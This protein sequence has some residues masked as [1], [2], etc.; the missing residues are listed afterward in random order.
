M[1]EGVE[2][3]SATRRSGG[4]VDRRA[5]LVGG[6]AAAGLA[7]A[8]RALA[9]GSPYPNRPIRVIVPFAAGGPSDIIARIVADALY[10]QLGQ[11]LVIDNRAGGGANIGIGVAA[12]AEPDGY[13]LLITT[14]AFVINPSLYK[15]IPFDP[16]K[17]FSPI[18]DLAISPQMLSVMP[19]YVNTLAEFIAKAK[20]APGALNYSSPGVGTQAQLTVE[21]LKLRA[22]ID[23]VHV[24]FS[25]GPPAVQAL[26]SGSVQLTTNAVPT[27]EK[28]AQAGTIHP[29]AVSGKAR[30]FALPD[31]PTLVESGFADFTVDAWTGVAAP[32]GTPPEI[33]QMLNR[34]INES[35]GSAE[36]KAGLARFSAIAQTGSPQDF[37]EL[38]ASELPK[39]AAIVKLAGARI[40][41]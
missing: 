25:G 24:P 29:L 10:P 33:V 22:G 32:A 8:P 12:R 4:G 20:A 2:S 28:L 30:Y 5:L 40:E 38:I 11:T 27:S 23:I 15:K 36:A 1:R 17:D 19:G 31:V 9:Q 18:S 13:T 26:L 34:S 3:M 39:W 21:L 16:I 7:A 35:L 41:Q 14:S 6:A 37:A